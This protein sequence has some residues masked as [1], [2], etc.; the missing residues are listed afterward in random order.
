MEQAVRLIG[1]RGQG[2]ANAT[3]IQNDLAASR[4]Q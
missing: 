2:L 1:R 3:L 4:D